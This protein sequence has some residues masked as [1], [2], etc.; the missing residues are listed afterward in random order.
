M[1]GVIASLSQAGLNTMQGSSTSQLPS[2]ITS[3]LAALNPMKSLSDKE[4]EDL[5]REKLLRV[6]AEIAVLDDQI[7]G[8][9][10]TK[11]QREALRDHP[12]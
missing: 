2:S 5:L 3:K 9:R 4:Y 12:S 10:A 8:L 6:D 7:A 1:L 11:D